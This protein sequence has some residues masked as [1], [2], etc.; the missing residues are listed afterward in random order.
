MLPE[1]Y[2]G[3]KKGTYELIPYVDWFYDDPRKGIQMTREGPRYSSGYARLFHSYGMITETLIYKPYADRVKS[4][5][6][7]IATLAEFVAGNSE[8]IRESRKKGMAQTKTL[9]RL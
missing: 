4:T 5:I 8:E 2:E 6:Q 3:M 9:A 7:F 1:L